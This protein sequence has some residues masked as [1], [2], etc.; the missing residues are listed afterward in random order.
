MSFESITRGFVD[1]GKM[2]GLAK[3]LAG[4]FVPGLKER[5]DGTGVSGLKAVVFTSGFDGKESRASYEFDAPGERKGCTQGA[6]G[7]AA[8]AS[9]TCRRCRRT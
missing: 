2:V 3:S 4:P 7:H 9:T 5:L 1:T 6:E 8:R